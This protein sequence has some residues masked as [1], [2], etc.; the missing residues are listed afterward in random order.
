[1][2]TL[3]LLLIPFLSLGQERFIGIKTDTAY[4][5]NWDMKKV[6]EETFTDNGGGF[7]IDTVYVENDSVMNVGFSDS[8]YHY[9]DIFR[10]ETI[11]DTLFT[12]MASGCLNSCYGVGC[13]RCKKNAECNCYCVLIGGC[14]S[15]DLAIF[16][17]NPM[18]ILIRERILTNQNP[19]E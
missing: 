12:S 10:F 18:S 15:K 8:E 3:L 2:K 5:F 19:E 11:N 1:M 7:S 16:Q 9:A 14:D 13:T 6:V 17:D 4:I